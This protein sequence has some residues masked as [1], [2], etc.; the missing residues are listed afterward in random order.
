M[1][2]CLFLDLSDPLTADRQVD[3]NGAQRASGLTVQ[4]QPLDDDALASHGGEAADSRIEQVPHDDRG[5]RSGIGNLGP[6][7]S[8]CATAIPD[9]FA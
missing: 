6:G 5:V 3:R 1:S 9:A 2:E 7:E 4:A 8:R